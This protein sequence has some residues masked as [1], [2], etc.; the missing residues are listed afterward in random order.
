MFA[1]FR[2]IFGENANR[3]L[4]A[5]VGVLG[6]IAGLV[7]IKKPFETLIVFALIIGIW[8][9]VAGIV[10]FVAAFALREGRGTNIFLAII[11][12]VAGIVIL[13]WPELG[14]ATLAVIF[15]IVLVIRGLL[16]TYVGFQLRHVV[17]DLDGAP[18]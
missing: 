1:I 10:R 12:V 13:S 5:L 15:G 6:A 2:S 11:D 16:L 18:A 8:L 3:G 7:L 4:L 14:L 17:E 9:I